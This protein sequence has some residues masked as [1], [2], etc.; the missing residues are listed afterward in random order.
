MY[1]SGTLDNLRKYYQ[2]ISYV[3]PFQK[4]CLQYVKWFS[5]WYFEDHYSIK[6]FLSIKVCTI[7]AENK[8]NV[9]SSL[10]KASASIDNGFKDLKAW[11]KGKRRFV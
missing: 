10:Y 5:V 1:N 9:S 8:T 7:F 3:I 6:V 4:N 11:E 2:G